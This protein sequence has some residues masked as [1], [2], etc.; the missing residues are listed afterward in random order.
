MGQ[1]CSAPTPAAASGW[2]RV[3][4]RRKPLQGLREAVSLRARGQ[5]TAEWAK[6]AARPTPTPRASGQKSGAAIAGNG[7]RRPAGEDNYACAPVESVR[8]QVRMS[9]WDLPD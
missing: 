9:G 5:S 1:G 6:A 2:V 3:K 7:G 8:C 4:A